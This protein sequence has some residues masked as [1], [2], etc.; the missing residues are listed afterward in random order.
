MLTLHQPGLA[1]SQTL[2]LPEKINI[3]IH[4]IGQDQ[5]AA[6]L[7]GMDGITLGGIKINFQLHHDQLD[8]I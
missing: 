4:M 1:S 8:E 5:A 7:T 3:H 6:S 2:S